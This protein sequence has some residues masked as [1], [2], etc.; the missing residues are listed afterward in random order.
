MMEFSLD[1]LVVGG[2]E[3]R[4]QN[5]EFR[6]DENVFDL[7]GWVE[8]QFS[9]LTDLWEQNYKKGDKLPL[10]SGFIWIGES[11]K[12]F[13][14]LSLNNSQFIVYYMHPD[15]MDGKD[16]CVKFSDISKV[17]ADVVSKAAKVKDFNY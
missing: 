7:A 3:C 13:A 9:H 16:W 14:M 6:Q 8:N 5:K 12:P 1:G 10:I 15:Y 4:F 17:S 11:N 2:I